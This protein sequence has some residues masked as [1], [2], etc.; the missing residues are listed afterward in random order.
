MID[1]ITKGD[2]YQFEVYGGDEMDGMTE[3]FGPDKEDDAIEYA[4]KNNLKSV[5]RVYLNYTLLGN[6]WEID[7]MF[8]YEELVWKN[9]NIE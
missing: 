5:E 6:N 3:F 2:N 8:D 9:D 1:T 7:P 4:K